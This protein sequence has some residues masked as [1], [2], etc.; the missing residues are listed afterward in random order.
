MLSNMGLDPA[1]LCERNVWF[2]NTE[3]PQVILELSSL[4]FNGGD[5]R[6]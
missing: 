1:H 5:T 2:N 3:L 4:V 6:K